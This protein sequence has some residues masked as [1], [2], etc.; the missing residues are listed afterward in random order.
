MLGQ[1]I[2]KKSWRY[3]FEGMLHLATYY[4]NLCNY[5]RDKV[6][7]EDNAARIVPW[8][9]LP[10]PNI[11]DEIRAVKFLKNKNKELMESGIAK[12]YWEVFNDLDNFDPYNL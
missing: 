4:L 10:D 7:Q 3:E 12:T 9:F 6:V 1:Y 5:Y 8:Y 11:Q 2:L